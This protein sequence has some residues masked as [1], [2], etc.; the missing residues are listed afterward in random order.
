MLSQCKNFN[1]KLINYLKMKVM[2]KKLLI[3]LGIIYIG[4]KFHILK[5]KKYLLQKKN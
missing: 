1:E 3:N 2:K 4:I 5:W